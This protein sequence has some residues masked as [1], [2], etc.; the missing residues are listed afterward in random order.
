M[1]WNPA[2]EGALDLARLRTAAALLPRSETSHIYGF[3]SA[4]IPPPR[5]L[6]GSRFAQDVFVAYSSS[7]IRDLP[8]WKKAFM[9]G[10]YFLRDPLRVFDPKLVPDNAARAAYRPLPSH[11][12]EDLSTGTSCPR[13]QSNSCFIDTALVTM[14]VATDAY[15]S[16]FLA[17]MS[18]EVPEL[19]MDAAAKDRHKEGIGGR[20]LIDY[21]IYW[22]EFIDPKTDFPATRDV[23]LEIG[24]T[25]RDIARE[26]AWAMRTPGESERKMK[27]L[28]ESMRAALDKCDPGHT[29][30][31]TRRQE[32]A[33]VIYDKLIG[34]SGW[35][36]RFI[37]PRFSLT[38]LSR[39]DGLA[40][41][42]PMTTN[43]DLQSTIPHIDAAY[44]PKAGGGRRDFQD[45]VDE[46]VVQTR[47]Y[48]SNDEVLERSGNLN[49]TVAKLAA[50]AKEHG[51]VDVAR[52]IEGIEAEGR[53]SAMTPI[54]KTEV[55]TLADHPGSGVVVFGSVDLRRFRNDQGELVDRPPDQVQKPVLPIHRVIRVRIGLGKAADVNY[56]VFSVIIK[57]GGGGGGH[58]WCQF[59]DRSGTRYRYDDTD[60][61]A[62]RFVTDEPEADREIEDMSVY[63]FARRVVTEEEPREEPPPGSPPAIPET[64]PPAEPPR[65]PRITSE[66]DWD[67]WSRLVDGDRYTRDKLIGDLTVVLPH[68]GSVLAIHG[69]DLERK[70]IASIFPT[71]FVTAQIIDTFGPVYAGGNYVAP[72]RDM[73]RIYVDPHRGTADAHA[74]IK[75][76]LEENRW[77][78]IPLSN[79]RGTRF[80]LQPGDHWSLLVLYKEEE[81]PDTVVALHYDS[82]AKEDKPGSATVNDR[83]SLEVMHML[84]RHGTVPQNTFATPV[85]SCI[86]QPLK[87]REDDPRGAACAPIV[88]GYI[89]ALSSG[90]G[91]RGVAEADEE[92][93]I[94][95]MDDIL[96]NALPALGKGEGDEDLMRKM[97]ALQSLLMNMQRAARDY[98]LLPV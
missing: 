50:H 9:I 24:L 84:G 11:P 4:L 34:S 12:R 71:E 89:K 73:L 13:N 56:T 41:E 43:A 61:P 45:I 90:T 33:L 83:V 92:V 87:T 66:E 53:T 8:L 68:P 6:T 79:V 85:D 3:L 59:W 35:G 58:Y 86:R 97:V 63:F 36:P 49:S 28:V 21:D 72:I 78:F 26:I 44:N 16:V 60:S 5:S 42:P 88:L 80:D 20:E 55:A 94:G 51:L 47:I 52:R 96:A 76:A 2:A 64:P 62:L 39:F 77:V 17:R 40:V 18:R 22:C 95:I 46:T 25:V 74:A 27:D 38:S 15:D 67:V 23:I 69:N 48:T 91:M 75:E 32:D 70:D 7:V 29:V 31:L 19:Q 54:E 57:S 10:G 1:T 37:M 65:A 82:K 30:P 93:R 98:Y 14:F 81:D